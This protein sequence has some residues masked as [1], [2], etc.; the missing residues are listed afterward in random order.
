MSRAYNLNKE[1]KKNFKASFSNENSFPVPVNSNYEDYIEEK[2][3]RYGF[4][5]TNDNSPAILLQPKSSLKNE[6][7]KHN[8]LKISEEEN[9]KFMCKPGSS[10]KA[11]FKKLKFFLGRL[12]DAKKFYTLNR[13]I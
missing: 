11:K 7:N 9:S 2:K 6:E 1:E 10:T 4:D 5:F 12:E 3:K 13:E 8:L